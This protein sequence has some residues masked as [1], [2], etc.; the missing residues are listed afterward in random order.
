MVRRGA[1]LKPRASVSAR[2]M[3]QRRPGPLRV[4]VVGGDG[5][6]ATPVVDAGVEQQPEVIRQVRRGLHVYL[7]R[8]DEPGQSNGVQEDLLRAGRRPVH[9][10]ARLGQEVLDDHLLH[11]AVTGVAGGDGLEGLDAIGAAFADA[12]QD[13]GRERDGRARRRPREWPAGV[14]ASCPGSR[15]GRRDRGAASRSSCPGWRSRSAVGPA[16][17]EKGRRRWRAAAARFPR[18]PAG[19]SPP[20]TRRS[21]RNRALP[22][23]RRPPDSAP[24]DARRG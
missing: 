20:D 3:S 4:D 16:R 15:G 7:G 9:R 17:R 11:V 21:S 14:P 12:D 19:T 24:P 23:R 5:G 10:R 8:Q 6:D 1:R 13:A 22:A 2:S 18:S